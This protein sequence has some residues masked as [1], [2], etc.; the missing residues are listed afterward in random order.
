M[1][2]AWGDHRDSCVSVGNEKE[3]DEGKL[4]GTE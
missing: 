1:V 4:P 2:S 3:A